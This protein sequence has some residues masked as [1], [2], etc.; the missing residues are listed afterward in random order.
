V[1]EVVIEEDEG[2]LVE[3]VAIEEDP[4]KH[5]FKADLALKLQCLLCVEEV[6]VRLFGCIID[7][8]ARLIFAISIYNKSSTSTR[9]SQLTKHEDEVDRC[10]PNSSFGAQLTLNHSL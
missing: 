2:V 5:I 10:N 3:G 4:R 8:F 6:F 1:E 7:R 9:S